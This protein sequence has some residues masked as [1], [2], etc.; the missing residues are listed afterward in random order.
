MS[1]LMGATNT[2]TSSAYREVRKMAPRP[3]QVVKKAQSRGFHKK[4][5]DGVDG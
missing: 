2:T 3:P 5:C 1:L 4:L